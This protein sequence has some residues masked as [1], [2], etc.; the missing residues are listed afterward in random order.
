MPNF[1]VHIM[2]PPLTDTQQEKVKDVIF[3]EGYKAH[4]EATPFGSTLSINIDNEEMDDP[5][6]GPSYLMK[7]IVREIEMCMF[8]GGSIQYQHDHWTHKEQKDCKYGDKLFESIPAPVLQPLNEGVA[9]DYEI[10]KV[11]TSHYIVGSHD[12]ASPVKRM[13]AV[14][15]AL[16]HGFGEDWLKKRGE[17][18]HGIGRG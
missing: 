5:M 14:G 15:E 2:L 18:G 4:L 17:Y 8:C 6:A 16:R 13:Q 3:R 1:D 12:K 9:V 10:P 11:G 7:E